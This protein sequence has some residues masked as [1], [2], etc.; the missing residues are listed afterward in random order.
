MYETTKVNQNIRI[1]KFNVKTKKTY[2][3][4]VIYVFHIIHK[5]LIYICPIRVSPLGA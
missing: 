2:M 1:P 4:V 5:I 3:Y